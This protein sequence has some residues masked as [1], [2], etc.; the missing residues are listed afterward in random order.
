MRYCRCGLSDDIGDFHSLRFEAFWASSQSYL[1]QDDKQHNPWYLAL[2][3]LH[4]NPPSQKQKVNLLWNNPTARWH[5]LWRRRLHWGTKC[6]HCDGCRLLCGR[7]KCLWCTIPSLLYL[8]VEGCQENYPDEFCSKYPPEGIPN[9]WVLKD[10]RGGVKTEN[11]W[12]HLLEISFKLSG[13]DQWMTG[14]PNSTSPVKC[15]QKVFSNNCYSFMD[16]RII[17]THYFFGSA[18]WSL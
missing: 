14:A 8:L 17:G 12:N 18:K 5:Q 16:I 2:G 7:W 3:Q 10:Q 11:I 4:N 9:K 13:R 1:F 15:S 6:G